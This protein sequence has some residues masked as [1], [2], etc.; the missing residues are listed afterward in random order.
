MLYHAKL[1]ENNATI[2]ENRLCY[3]NV[4]ENRFGI[5]E[6]SI[7]ENDSSPFM[8]IVNVTPFQLEKENNT[9]A[10]LY[11]FNY[12]YG[13]GLGKN[14]FRLEADDVFN[15][16]ASN[17]QKIFSKQLSYGNRTETGSAGSWETT[18]KSIV[19]ERQAV[20]FV[21]IL[22]GALGVVIIIML[23]RFRLR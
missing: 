8:G 4:S 9:Y 5:K 22:F 11:R 19:F 7:L 21:T 23:L 15:G 17:E 18:R 2:A 12:T 10:Y 6:I 1:Q 13:N 14:D 16:N 3:F 20:Q